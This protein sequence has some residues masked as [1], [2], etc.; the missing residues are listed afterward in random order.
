MRERNFRH[1]SPTTEDGRCKE[2]KKRWLQIGLY[3]I[4]PWKY[5]KRYSSCDWDLYIFVVFPPS[6]FYLIQTKKKKKKKGNSYENC[7]IAQVI[8]ARRKKKVII[9]SSISS[10]V[11]I[12]SN[13]LGSVSIYLSLYNLLYVLFISNSMVWHWQYEGRKPK[14]IY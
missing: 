14:N 2:L 3:V 9:P 10:Y 11:C 13:S 6:N 1:S 12:Q 4:L 5:K 7:L 8:Q